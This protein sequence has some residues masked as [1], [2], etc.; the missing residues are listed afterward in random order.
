MQAK[1][2]KK[3]DEIRIIAPSKSLATQP[4]SI[5]KIAEKRFSKMGLKVSYSKNCYK[6]NDFDSSSI[7][8][9]I[10]DL[11]EAF[12]DKNVKA[13][14]CAVGGYNSNQL[15]DKINYQIIKNNPKIFCGSSDIT[16]LNNA[17][18]AKTDLITYQ[19]P[20]FFSFGMKEGFEYTQEYFEKIFFTKEDICYSSAKEWSDDEWKNS[21]IKRN[22]RENKGF[23]IIQRGSC[24]GKI[25]GGNLCTLNL[26]QGTEFMPSFENSILFLEDDVLSEESFIGEFDRN[27]ESLSQQKDFK[28]VKGIVFGRFQNSS[29]MTINKLK[30]IIESKEKLRGIP[31]LAN[32]DFG[33]TNP[34]I[35]FPIGGQVSIYDLDIKI[36]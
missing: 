35:I 23:Q 25:I 5:I 8:F 6:K 33:H 28:C 36:F 10:S 3:G 22:F 7:K 18:F 13:I 26:L 24:K 14:L 17:I 16:A 30:K 2:L 19:G 9:R 31:I 27:L 12:L 1:K 34:I 32:C 4:K 29:K 15:I 21:Q 11:E 20:N